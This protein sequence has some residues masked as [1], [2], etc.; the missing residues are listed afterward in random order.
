MPNE[1][2]AAPVRRMAKNTRA[3]ET[4][5]PDRRLIIEKAGYSPDIGGSTIRFV[6]PL[7]SI[8]PAVSSKS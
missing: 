4:A 3:L 5:A 6:P 1:D 2:Q 8:D 7:A